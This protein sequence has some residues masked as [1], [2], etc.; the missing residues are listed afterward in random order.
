[1]NVFSTNRQFD[2]VVSIEMF[3]HMRN[4]ETLHSRIAAWLRPEGKLFVHVFCHREHAYPFETEG[5]DDWMG[6][7]FFTGGIMPS[8]DLLL[9]F[10]EELVLQKRWS[11]SGTHY[12]QTLEAWLQNCDRERNRLRSLFEA[13]LGRPDGA[14]G[15]LMHFN[16]TTG[17]GQILG[18]L[19]GGS[20]QF[21]EAD[22]VTGAAV[23]GWIGTALVQWGL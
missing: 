21:T 6:R 4:Y 1:M 10:Q 18:L 19:I 20:M 9:H 2:R 13:D 3:E 7:H 22:T 15:M 17:E 16:V 14:F 11:V 8:D 12:T 23:R 5:T